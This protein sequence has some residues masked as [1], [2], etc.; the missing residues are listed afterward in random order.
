MKKQEKISFVC[1]V[2]GKEFE[3]EELAMACESEHA[4]KLELE[5]NKQTKIDEIKAK[6]T[7]LAELQK[8]Y[9]EEYECCNGCCDCKCEDFSSS[10]TNIN[11]EE[12]FYINGKKV[13]RSE[14]IKNTD[15]N[16]L[17]GLFGKIPKWFLLK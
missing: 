11:G 2:C 1:D 7:E 15:N 9:D 16:F 14:Y 6:Q 10:Y 4:K 8:K 12:T 3:T 17:G 5:K 13:D